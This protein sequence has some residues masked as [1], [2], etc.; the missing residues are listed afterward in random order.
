MFPATSL[1]SGSGRTTSLNL[2]LLQ[3]H[4]IRFH[5]HETTLDFELAIHFTWPSSHLQGDFSADKN[6]F[7]LFTLSLIDLL[8][9]SE[10]STID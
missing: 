2:N 9:L 5:S 6:F 4:L 10:S 7:Y 1:G 3:F 8:N